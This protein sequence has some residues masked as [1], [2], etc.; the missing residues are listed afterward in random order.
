MSC[1]SVSES[2]PSQAQINE[3]TTRPAASR[4]RSTMQVL[5]TMIE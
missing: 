4:W 1:H 2:G 5:D 3:A